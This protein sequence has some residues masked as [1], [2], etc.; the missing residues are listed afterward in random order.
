MRT[1]VLLAVGTVLGLIAL[2]GGKHDSHALSPYLIASESN[3]DAAN[4]YTVTLI[5]NVNLKSF[6]RLATAIPSKAACLQ[7][8]AVGSV[9]MLSKTEADFIERHEAYGN[10]MRY[11]A[12]RSDKIPFGSIR[13]STGILYKFDGLDLLVAQGVWVTETL[14]F[15][16][17][18]GVK[19]VGSVKEMEYTYVLAETIDRHNQVELRLDG[20]DLHLKIDT[21]SFPMDIE[22]VQ[23]HL[24]LSGGVIVCQEQ[25]DLSRKEDCNLVLRMPPDTDYWYLTL[26]MSNLEELFDKSYSY[27]YFGWLEEASKLNT[28][29]KATR[30][31]AIFSLKI[32]LNSLRG[33]G[34]GRE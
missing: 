30:P 1:V 10:P 4:D 14:S 7:E 18:A 26:Y 28:L 3:Q 25:V 32:R 23:I 22:D 6:Q 16:T 24:C 20:N 19:M 34:F 17:Y 33:N 15:L 12:H 29:L 27:A 21:S 9:P 8:Q 5:G 13:D 2:E 11:E 31:G